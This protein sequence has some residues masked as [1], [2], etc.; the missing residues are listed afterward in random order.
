MRTRF[1]ILVPLIAQPIAAQQLQLH[2]DP[3]H[4]IAPAANPKNFPEIYFEYFRSFPRDSS[5][6]QLGSFLLKMECDLLGV[7]DNIGRSY[8]QASQSFKCW[9][10][11]IFLNIQYSG[12]LGIAEPGAYG[13]YLTNTYSLGAA[14][15]FQWDDVTWSAS[16]DYTYTA[17]A[18]PSQDARVSLYWWK[19]VM[20]YTI[21]FAGDIQCWTLDKGRGDAASA[22]LRGKRV[23]FYGEPQVWV[24]LGKQFS[25]GT[26][27]TLYYHIL[28][29]DERVQAFPTLAVRYKV[30]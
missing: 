2:Y 21:E 14:I 26:K 4:W 27:I 25:I 24:N 16:A 18:I 8:F 20:E 13:Y 22:G 23:S 9:E 19:G 17:F 7:K 1:L 28:T 3:R 15:P 29:T 10:P 6:V 30:P 5:L 11:D 12:G